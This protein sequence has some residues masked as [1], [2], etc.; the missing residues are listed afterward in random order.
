MNTIFFHL[1]VPKAL[2]LHI[3]LILGVTIGEQNISGFLE[4]PQA[5]FLAGSAAMA[6]LSKTL[7]I[8][9]ANPFPTKCMDNMKEHNFPVLYNQKVCQFLKNTIQQ[10]STTKN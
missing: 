6:R 2:V 7:I 3:P 5:A 9:K 1:Y 4:M 10:Y 8:R